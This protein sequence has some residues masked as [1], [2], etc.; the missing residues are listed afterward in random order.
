VTTG[1]CPALALCLFAQDRS[2]SLITA[3]LW[4]SDTPPRQRVCTRVGWLRDAA[5]RR[6]TCA[7]NSSCDITCG[8]RRPVSPLLSSS[9]PVAA[10]R[11]R[12]VDMGVL[13]L[14]HGT[15][16]L[17]GCCNRTYTC[18]H[19]HHPFSLEY[20][21]AS[22]VLIPQRVWVRIQQI[23]RFRIQRRRTLSAF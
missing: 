19:H 11:Q 8:Y 17:A 15:F 4:D 18:G 16:E 21:C 1:R 7:L 10:R 20:I 14:I 5:R 9:V 23:V 13:G 12:S 2:G 22:I 3:I 6:C